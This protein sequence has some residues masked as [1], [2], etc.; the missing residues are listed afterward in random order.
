MQ[1]CKMRAKHL[2]LLQPPYLS[3]FLSL[4]GVIFVLMI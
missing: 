1:S 4:F 2:S 3:F